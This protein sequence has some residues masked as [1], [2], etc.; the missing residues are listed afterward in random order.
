MQWQN[1]EMQQQEGEEYLQYQIP[2][3]ACGKV[4]TDEQME[5]LRKQIVAYAVISE[6]LAEM[7]KAMSAHRDFT[8]FSLFFFDL[9]P[10]FFLPVIYVLLVI[11]NAFG[12]EVN[13]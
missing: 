2:N 9:P 8:G 7:H 4:M 1:Q 10:F 13:A 12:H 6:Q 3:G 5:E 11:I